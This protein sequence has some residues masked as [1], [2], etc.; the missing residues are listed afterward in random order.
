MK[1]II[2]ALGISTSIVGCATTQPL[3]S[4]QMQ[5]LNQLRTELQTKP[6][7]LVVNPCLIRNE[8]GKDQLM[9][10]PAQLTSERFIETFTQQLMQ[11]NVKVQHTAVPFICGS[12]PAD[13][14]TKYDF[15]D[16]NGKRLPISHS[17][18]LNPHNNILTDE[19]KTAVLALNQFIAKSEAYTIARAQK[20][21]PKLAAP[22]LDETSI[23]T[24]KDWANSDYLFLASLDGLEASM[25]SKFAYGAFSLTV[26]AA[27]MGAGAVVTYIPKEGQHYTVHLID[28]NQSQSTWKNSNVLKGKIFDT[29][30]HSLIAKDIFKPLFETNMK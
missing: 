22:Q 13:Q 2:V 25:G 3:S 6:V 8:L 26:S 24:L 17:P 12:M 4:E 29:D 10:E 16:A 20:P 30:H 15:K 5:K 21:N 9:N 1:K 27:T 14:L 19:Q 11:Y 28:L 23:R 18:L 7:S